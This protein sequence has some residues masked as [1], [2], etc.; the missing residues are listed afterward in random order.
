[1]KRM[2]FD[3]R[4]LRFLLVG[5]INTVVGMGTMFLLYNWGGCGYW[6]SSACNYLVGGTVSYFL[7]KYYTFEQKERDSKYVFRFICNT[8]LCYLI[9][10]G[11]AKPLV[12][13]LPLGLSEH[14]M[15]NLA[16]LCGAGLY[17]LLG[18]I[19]QRLFVFRL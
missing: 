16:M 3:R 5:V 15:G 19:G 13:Q 8:L 11:A 14:M 18:Y 17:T 4:F 6:F 12:L 7:N 1:M 10:Y 9:A 2:L